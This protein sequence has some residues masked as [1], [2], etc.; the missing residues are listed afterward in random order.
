MECRFQEPYIKPGKRETSIL[1][2]TN[3]FGVFAGS[4]NIREADAW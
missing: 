4:G 2:G 1:N 3:L